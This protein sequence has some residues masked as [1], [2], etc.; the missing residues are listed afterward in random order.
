M[1]AI[2]D[3]EV[4]PDLIVGT[5]VGALHGALVQAAP[6]GQTIDDWIDQR[7]PA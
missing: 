6:Q 7:A 2:L 5:S 1:R 3:R 4:K